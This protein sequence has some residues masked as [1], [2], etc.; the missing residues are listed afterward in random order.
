MQDTNLNRASTDERIDPATENLQQ[1]LLTEFA[2][3]SKR[4][5]EDVK[6]QLLTLAAS[7][8]VGTPEVGHGC[9]SVKFW[10]A[11]SDCY[12]GDK[13][14]QPVLLVASIWTELPLNNVGQLRFKS[15]T[16]G[17]IY[18]ISSN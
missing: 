3:N 12:V 13:D 10:T 14:S 17:A 7:S 1:A 5:T 15:A 4:S 18:I 11:M 9:N 8:V 16:G 2:R 6:F